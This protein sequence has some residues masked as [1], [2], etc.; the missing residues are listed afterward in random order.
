MAPEWAPAGVEWIIF[1]SAL[2]FSV[3]LLPQLVR[4]LRLGRADDF[5]LP[6]ILIV[7]AAS[8]LALLYFLIVDPGGWYVYYGYLANIAVWSVVAWYRIFPRPGSPGHE[9]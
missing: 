5:S 9:V 6:F 4:T 2:A 7:I 3:A 1:V 8:I